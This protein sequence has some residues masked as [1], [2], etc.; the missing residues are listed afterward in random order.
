MGYNGGTWVAMMDIIEKG[1]EDIKKEI[2][3]KILTVE[4]KMLEM[5]GALKDDDCAPLKHTFADGMYI[6]EITMPKG[7]LFI[8]KIHKFTHP[9]FV[10]KGECSVLTEDG[11]V[12]IKAPYSGITQPGTKRILYIHEDTVWTTVHSTKETDLKKI[13]EEII[14]KSYEE[15][16]IE[17][18]KCKEENLLLTFIDK[19][20]YEGG[21]T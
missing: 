1:T 5:P 4:A 20:I 13:E 16:G 19:V 8:S 15:I 7:K 21:E 12:R 10:L 2:R 9:F 3:G 6:R 18:D 11:I 14:A 17:Y